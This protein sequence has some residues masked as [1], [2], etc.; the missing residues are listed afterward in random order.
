[1]T[2]ERRSS[3]DLQDRLQASLGDAYVIDHELAPGGMSRLFLATEASL[4]RKV[5]IKLLPPETLSD[6]SAARFQREV[7]LAAHLQHPHI[8]PVLTTGTT[9]DGIFYYI[10]PYVAGESL[11]QRLEQPERMPIFEAMR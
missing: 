4:E 7:L 1:M 5:V 3:D 8:L 10:M 11:R 6:V 2:V 9:R